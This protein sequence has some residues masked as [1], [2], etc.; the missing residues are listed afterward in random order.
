MQLKSDHRAWRTHE[1]AQRLLAGRDRNVSA[2]PNLLLGPHDNPALAGLDTVH[3]G[4]TDHFRASAFR[5]C[6]QRR[7]KLKAR[8]TGGRE[9]QRRR[10]L[11]LA[12]D[13]SET[14]NP[15]RAKAVHVNSK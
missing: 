7:V 11:L 2:P 5:R 9:R 15:A 14:S 8:E 3:G 1:A 12:F 10:S 13:Y 6:K 4:T